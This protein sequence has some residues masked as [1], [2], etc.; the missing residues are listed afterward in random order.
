MQLKSIQSS[1]DSKIQFENASN[2]FMFANR[3][4]QETNCQNRDSVKIKFNIFRKRHLLD[5]IR[6]GQFI[7]SKQSVK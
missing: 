1:S 6:K 7:V 4:H 5:I 2:D 3:N